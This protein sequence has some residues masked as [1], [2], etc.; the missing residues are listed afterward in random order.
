VALAEVSIVVIVAECSMQLVIQK[1][2]QMTS[3][4]LIRDK[5]NIPSEYRRAIG[6]P[7]EEG[8]TKYFR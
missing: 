8:K 2:R 1:G 6:W 7:K 4:E 3:S 5:I